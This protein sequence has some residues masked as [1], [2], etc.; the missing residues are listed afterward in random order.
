MFTKDQIKS[1]HRVKG[2]LYQSKNFTKLRVVMLPKRISI[3]RA[4]QN[5]K[6]KQYEYL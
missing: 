2:P 1:I 6:S 3:Y 4:T 5:R